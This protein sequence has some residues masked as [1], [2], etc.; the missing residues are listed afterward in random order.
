M[1]RLHSKIES[2]LFVSHKPLSVQ[3]IANLLKEEKDKVKETLDQLVSQYQEGKRGVAVIKINQSYQMVSAPDN[4]KIVKEFLKDEQTGELTKPS[5][6][7]LTIIAYRG[8]ISKAELD[9][10]RGV[11]CSLILRNLMIKGLVEAKDD[12]KRMATYYSITMDFM[13]HLGISQLAELPDYHKLNE[14][15]NLE[16]LLNPELA[17]EEKKSKLQEQLDRQKEERLQLEQEN[18]PEPEAS[19]DQPEQSKQSQEQIN[20]EEDDSTLNT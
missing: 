20:Q 8:P 15:E 2:L 7:T 13:R 9:T 12:K 16:K 1:S 19:A 5:L 11:N 4:G 17:E 14:N 3:K 18:Q 6:E 10:I